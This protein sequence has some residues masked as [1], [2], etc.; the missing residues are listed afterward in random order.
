MPDEAQFAVFARLRD[1]RKVLSE[2]EAIHGHARADAVAEAQGGASIEGAYLRVTANK[3]QPP[4]SHT[5]NDLPSPPH[6]QSTR[7]RT[8]EVIVLAS[9]LPCGVTVP[10][11]IPPAR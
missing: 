9:P 6:M 4:F 10:L 11:P 5:R 7:R 8:G 2:M 1:L 3:K